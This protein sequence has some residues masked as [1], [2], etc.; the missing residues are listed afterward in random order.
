MRIR[1]APKELINNNS[2]D[3]KHHAPT[4]PKNCKLKLE[5]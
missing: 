5:L 4:E 1:S 3:Y 2:K